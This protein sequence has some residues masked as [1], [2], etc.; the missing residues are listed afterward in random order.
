M[1]WGARQHGE[2]CP[3]FF[4]H[5]PK[6]FRSCDFLSRGLGKEDAQG[7]LP[8][9]GPEPESPSGYAQ[10]NFTCGRQVLC[11]INIITSYRNGTFTK[12]SL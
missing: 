9:K 2:A 12:F 3:V 4:I 5:W 8:S 11:V 1:G 7:T 10:V 6:C